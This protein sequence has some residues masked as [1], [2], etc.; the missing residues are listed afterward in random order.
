MDNPV[1]SIYNTDSDQ[2][3]IMRIQVS[4]DRYSNVMR[5][6]R[7]KKLDTIMEY[8]KKI[9]AVKIIN[10]QKDFERNYKNA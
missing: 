4:F 1:P 2:D 9:D 10:L 6:L 5:D 8:R 7:N 3:K